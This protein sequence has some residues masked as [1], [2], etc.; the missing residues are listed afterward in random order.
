[1]KKMSVFFFCCLLF[2]TSFA[3][4]QVIS[5][6][7]PSIWVLLFQGEKVQVP[8]FGTHQLGQGAS[9]LEL[10]ALELADDMIYTHGFCVIKEDEQGYYVLQNLEVMP[11]FLVNLQEKDMLVEAHKTAFILRPGEER[12]LQ[13]VYITYDTVIELK[14]S[15]IEGDIGV[16]PPASWHKVSFKNG[17]GRVEL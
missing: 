14:I 12:E 8:A 2:F 16:L 11:I 6:Q 10:Y 17:R 13:D 7:G 9:P 4:A 1:M 5:N 3:Q 15:K